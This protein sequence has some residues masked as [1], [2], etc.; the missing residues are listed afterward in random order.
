[1]LGI[2]FTWFVLLL[3]VGLV[4]LGARALLRWRG[5]WRWAALVPLVLVFGV[6]LKIVME[7]RADPTSHN[8]WPF[9]VLFAVIAAGAL[10]GVLEL[11][12][13]G[14]ARFGFGGQG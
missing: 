12:R 6:V 3:G 2:T 5:V 11:I 7:V 10:L 8:L 13:I 9:E 4:L 14:A 1:M